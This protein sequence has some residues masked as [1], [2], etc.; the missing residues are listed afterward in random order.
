MIQMLCLLVL[1]AD[2]EAIAARIVQ[3][4]VIRGSFEQKKIMK[5]FKKPLISQGKVVVSRDQG[6][7]WRTTWPFQ[8][9]LKISRNQ[10][11]S[12]SSGRVVFQLAASNNPAVMAINTLLFSLL[13]GDMAELESSFDLTSVLRGNTGWHVTLKPKISAVKQLFSTI[14]VAGDAYVRSIELTEASGDTTAFVFAE[15]SAD[16]T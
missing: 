11:V 15:I 2:H 16:P 13:S 7:E 3:A 10:I 9:D 8:N 1:L 4:P 12:T 6:I 5:G 14:E